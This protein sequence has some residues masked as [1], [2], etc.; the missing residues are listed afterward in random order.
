M[1]A[2]SRLLQIAN[3]MLVA[4]G[5]SK[6]LAHALELPGQPRLD[7]EPYLAVQ[8]ICYPGFTIAIGRSCA[9]AGNIP[10]SHAPRWPRSASSRWSRR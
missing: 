1:H 7:K 5:M 4:F 8:S 6:A 9:T 10:A 2:M 3:V